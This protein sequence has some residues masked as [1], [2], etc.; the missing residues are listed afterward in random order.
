MGQPGPQKLL[1][2]ESQ[3]EPR[4]ELSEG[5]ARGGQQ[6]WR[7]PQEGPA[8]RGRQGPPATRRPPQT[9]ALCATALTPA[10]FWLTR[11]GI[12]TKHP[13]ETPL[14]WERGHV[15]FL[16]TVNSPRDSLS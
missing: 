4:P 2:L 10:S 1:A 15:S 14:W 3:D 16:T 13:W 7:Q 5:E 12:S 11:S 8:R 6:E 9:Q